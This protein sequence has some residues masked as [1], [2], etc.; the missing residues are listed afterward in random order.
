MVYYNSTWKTDFLRGQSY[1][2]YRLCNKTLRN[3]GLVYDGEL[4][5]WN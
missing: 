1:E 3:D 4:G 5:Q 2:E